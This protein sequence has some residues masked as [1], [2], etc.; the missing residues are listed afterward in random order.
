MK[1]SCN[2]GRF[3]SVN[4]MLYYYFSGCHLKRLR[5]GLFSLLWMV[6]LS[7]L[8]KHAVVYLWFL[9]KSE[10]KKILLVRC[11]WLNIELLV[12]LGSP[13]TTWTIKKPKRYR[14]FK[15]GLASKLASHRRKKEK[16]NCI[17]LIRCLKK[18]G[19]FLIGV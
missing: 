4:S 8:C 17:S 12:G 6:L 18:F 5:K 3:W 15:I 19:D 1:K 2:L 11:Q 13:T 16:C 14:A 10:A 7:L 9:R